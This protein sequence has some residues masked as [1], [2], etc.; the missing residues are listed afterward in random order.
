[1]LLPGVVLFPGETLPLRLHRQYDAGIIALAERSLVLS[2]NTNN[3]RDNNSVPQQQQG[4]AAAAAAAPA[5]VYFG[6]FCGLQAVGGALGAA[7]E[8][9]GTI[10]SVVSGR[11]IGDEQMVLLAQGCRRFRV[12]HLLGY[13]QVRSHFPPCFRLDE[14]HVHMVILHFCSA[15]YYRV[16]PGAQS[17]CCQTVSQC[18]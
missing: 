14:T 3:D 5:P 2:S 8:N 16:L 12:D 6:V 17:E 11:R 7:T 15:K 13:R 18:R 1:M 10:A 9:T 4:T